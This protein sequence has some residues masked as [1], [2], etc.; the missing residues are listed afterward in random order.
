MWYTVGMPYTGGT[1]S[2]R[3]KPQ[4]RSRKSRDNNTLY[5]VHCVMYTVQCTLYSIQSVLYNM[6]YIIYA[7]NKSKTLHLKKIRNAQCIWPSVQ[8]TVYK[9]IK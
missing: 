8:C 7:L 5:T 3:P 4:P 1:I 2:I 6:Q 9:R